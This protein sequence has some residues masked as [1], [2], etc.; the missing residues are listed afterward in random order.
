MDNEAFRYL[1]LSK[2]NILTENK[3]EYIKS[4]E[5]SS[6]NSISLINYI[7]S[8]SFLDIND[9]IMLNTSQSAQTEWANLALNLINKMVQL[10]NQINKDKQEL[11][12]TP[13]KIQNQSYSSLNEIYAS[14]LDFLK[15]NMKNLINSCSNLSY[16]AR[17]NS[18]TVFNDDFSALLE[19]RIRQEIQ[20]ENCSEKNSGLSKKFKEI[21]DFYK[22]TIDEIPQK[23]QR[24]QLNFNQNSINTYFSE[25]I[26][27]QDSVKSKFKIK[28]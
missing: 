19:E 18:V 10:N 23:I 4:W 15:L 20:K 5:M 11:P 8:L 9:I 14:K 26:E 16:L 17:I 7:C 24:N 25:I 22:K 6:K 3:E 2:N 13:G 28:F 12:S 27:I 1:A 21:F